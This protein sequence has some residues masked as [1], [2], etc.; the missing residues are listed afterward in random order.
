MHSGS[1]DCADTFVKQHSATIS[2]FHCFVAEVLLSPR[3]APFFSHPKHQK[4]S[5]KA[6]PNFFVHQNLLFL[7]PPKGEK[8][9]QP[10]RGSIPHRPSWYPYNG[11]VTWVGGFCWVFLNEVIENLN[12]WQSH[13]IHIYND[14]F[15]II[16]KISYIR[17][18]IM[19]P[20][21]GLHFRPSNVHFQKPVSTLPKPIHPIN[22]P[23]RW[24]ITLPETLL[25]SK[26]QL[27]PLVGEKPGP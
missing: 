24:R 9:H 17:Y 5:S 18:N 25:S 8:K 23:G 26:V 16:Y 20:K 2:R 4:L 11:P 1:F 13:I 15:Y 14:I 22:G 10:H 6:R 27:S 3:Q 7:T 12:H 19:F 21:N